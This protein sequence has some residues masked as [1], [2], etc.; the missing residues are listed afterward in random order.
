MN[1]RKY[2]IIKG[3]SL[4]CSIK[5][6]WHNLNTSTA[7]EDSHGR[8]GRSTLKINRYWKKICAFNQLDASLNK[9]EAKREWNFLCYLVSTCATSPKSLSI[10]V[11]FHTTAVYTDLKTSFF[12]PL[13]QVSTWHGQCSTWRNSSSYGGHHPWRHSRY[14][15]S[16][17]SGTSFPSSIS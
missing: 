3:I 11:F 1:I 4:G 6:Y 17:N 7:T 14:S 13:L 15:Q 9:L 10:S 12:S 2:L 16:S 8:I 5:A